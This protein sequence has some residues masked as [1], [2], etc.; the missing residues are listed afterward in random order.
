MGTQDYNVREN[1]T[2]VEKQ[3]ELREIQAKTF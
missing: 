3:E 1:M 2:S